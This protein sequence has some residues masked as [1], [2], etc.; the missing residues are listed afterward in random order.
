MPARY[1]VF[2]EIAPVYLAKSGSFFPRLS[3]LLPSRAEIRSRRRNTND[4]PGSSVRDQSDQLFHQP[5]GPEVLGVPGAV[6]LRPGI[7]RC[8]Q[9]SFACRI[10][11]HAARNRT[12]SE[13]GK[14]HLCPLDGRSYR[15]RADVIRGSNRFRPV[16]TSSVARK[17]MRLRPPVYPGGRR[18][19]DKTRRRADSSPLPAE[20]GW[21]E[22]APSRS[23]GRAS[24][25]M[26]AGRASH[27]GGMS[28]A[29]T[30][31]RFRG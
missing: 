30:S 15:P 7:D 21:D 4:S 26:S 8:F 22:G 16:A 3:I 12:T 31:A 18:R 24:S 20:L 19:A 5:I 1:S 14:S 28:N 13:S 6:R 27:G 11:R 17:G 10:C 25:C 29:A 2:L 9:K 23:Q